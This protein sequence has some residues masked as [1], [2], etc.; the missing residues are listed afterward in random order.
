MPTLDKALEQVPAG[1]KPR[2]FLLR[3]P[4]VVRSQA[5]LALHRRLVRSLCSFHSASS[6]RRSCERQRPRLVI[7]ATCSAGP[8]LASDLN[9]LSAPDVGDSVPTVEPSINGDGVHKTQ[10]S[11]V[12]ELQRG[13][14]PGT[15][16]PNL[17][18]LRRE[19][20]QLNLRD[21]FTSS[22]LFQLT[23]VDDTQDNPDVIDDLPTLPSLGL[24]LPDPGALATHN[25]DLPALQTLGFP[26]MTPVVPSVSSLTTPATS[27]VNTD[28]KRHK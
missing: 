7:N 21:A 3:N 13:V 18:Y 14:Q 17:E 24:P 23:R 20:A 6:Q 27:P 12:Q 9:A 8:V 1:F 16:V 15:S 19:D 28:K 10:Q 4:M 25:S 11:I 2:P 22:Q 5:I 26:S